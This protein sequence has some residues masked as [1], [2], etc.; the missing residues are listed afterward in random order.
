MRNAGAFHLIWGNHMTNVTTTFT[1]AFATGPESRPDVDARVLTLH[2]RNRVR[3][4]SI[5]I[6]ASLGLWGA[7]GYGIWSA[8]SALS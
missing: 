4:F 2:N 8:V 7:I 5:A 1:P 6:A 3:G